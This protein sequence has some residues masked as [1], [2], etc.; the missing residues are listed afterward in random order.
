MSAQNI[1]ISWGMEQSKHLELLCGSLG[2][3]FSLFSLVALGLCTCYRVRFGSF[4]KALVHSV[5]PSASLDIRKGM[6]F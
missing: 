3:L 6:G 2:L 4:Q 1:C 5:L